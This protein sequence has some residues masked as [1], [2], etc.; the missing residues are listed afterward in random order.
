M[1][2]IKNLLLY[3]WQLPQNLAG[4]LLVLVTKAKLFGLYTDEQLIGY[5]IS[6]R[7]G[8]NW[9][10]VSLGKYI[11]FSSPAFAT[12]TNIKHEYGHQLQSL[13]FGWLYLFLVGLPSFIANLIH[14]KNKV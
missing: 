3:L 8:R 5:Y 1:E 9:T 11:V 6:R 13:H 10:G 4:G 14:R 12:L 7:L 2:S